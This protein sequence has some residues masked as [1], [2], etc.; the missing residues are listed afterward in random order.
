MRPLATV[1]SNRNGSGLM[2][3][4]DGNDSAERFVAML[5]PGAIGSTPDP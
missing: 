4:S 1:M 3:H 5:T 2:K